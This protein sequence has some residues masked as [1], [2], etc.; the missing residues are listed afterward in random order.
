M[1]E[2]NLFYEFKKGLLENNPVLVQLL[3]LCPTLA[4][5]SS[6]INGIAMGLATT[7]VLLG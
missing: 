5:T 4:V 2:N 6:V 3:G 1:K 7:F